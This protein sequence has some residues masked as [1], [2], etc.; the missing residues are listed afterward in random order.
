MGSRAGKRRGGLVAWHGKTPEEQAAV[1]ARLRANRGRQTNTSLKARA[2]QAA[3]GRAGMDR[4]SARK[5]GFLADLGM[6][7]RGEAPACPT[8]AP[9]A[10]HVPPAR[11]A[12]PDGDAWLAALKAWAK[13]YRESLVKD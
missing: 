5:A 9:A 2:A 7:G 13:W 11:A 3:R 4:L 10:P 6:I 1:I 12:Y 8:A